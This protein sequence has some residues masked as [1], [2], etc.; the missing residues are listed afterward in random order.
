MSVEVGVYLRPPGTTT[1][2]VAELESA[3]CINFTKRADCNPGFFVFE[4]LGMR[5]NLHD[6]HGLQND[7]GIPFEKYPI[8]LDVWINYYGLNREKIENLRQGLALHFAHMVI[9][10]LKWPVIVVLNLQKVIFHWEG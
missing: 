10:K 6:E 8:E 2:V 5:I 7:M 1:H 3:L 4:A 9:Y